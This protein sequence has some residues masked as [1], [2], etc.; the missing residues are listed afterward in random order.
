MKDQNR[1]GIPDVAEEPEEFEI[2]ERKRW[3][4]LGLPF[5]FTTY[6]LSAK[7]L[8]VRAGLFT[9]V[10]DDILLY[11]IMDTSLRRTFGQK[12]FGLSSIMAV[13]S[14]HS[15]PELLIK[16]IRRGRAF[17]E[18]LDNQVESE[19]L[20][21]RFRAGE[22]AGVDADDDCACAVDGMERM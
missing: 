17:K 4:F 20:R 3:L 10:E 13:S 16:N 19:R 7:K 2:K 14:D 6:T 9:T 8:V 21:L 15:H 18:R 12:L 22:Y 11:R 5:T 1:N